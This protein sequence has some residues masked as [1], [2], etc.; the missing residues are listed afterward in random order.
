MLHRFFEQLYFSFLYKK[1]RVSGIS[2]PKQELSSVEKA[3]LEKIAEITH[4]LARE[5]VEK[6]FQENK[7][8]WVI[9]LRVFEKF[10]EGVAIHREYYRISTGKASGSSLLTGFQSFLADTDTGPSAE[11]D[12]LAKDEAFAEV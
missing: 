1:H 5:L 12:F 11:H 4:F 9:V 10:S 2:L 3:L 6:I 8:L 7:F